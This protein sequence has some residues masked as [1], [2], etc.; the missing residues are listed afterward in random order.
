MSLEQELKLVAKKMLEQ[1]CCNVVVD[2]KIPGVPFIRDGIRP[3]FDR[4]FSYVTRVGSRQDRR[5]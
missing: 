3:G 5:H 2:W 4:I 1:L